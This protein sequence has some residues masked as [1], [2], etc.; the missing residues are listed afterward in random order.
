MK[1]ITPKRLSLMAMLIALQIVLSK[2]LMLQLTDSIRLSIDSV[3]IILAGVWFGPVAGGFVGVLG[4]LLGTVLF[5][6]AGAYFPLLTVAFM[7]IGVVAGLLSYAVQK[8]PVAVRAI[9]C[10][11]PAEFAGSLLFKSFALGTLYGLPFF[12]MVGIRV[13]PVAV[14]MIADTILVGVLDKLL[15][16]M[17]KRDGSVR[18]NDSSGAAD[19]SLIG[20]SMQYDEALD[21]IHH[22]TWRGSRLGLERTNELLSRIGN[23]HRALKFIHIAGTNGKGSTAA[24]LATILTAAGYRVGLYTSPFINRFNERMQVD[25]VSIPDDELAGITSYVRPHADEMADHPTEFEL[26]TVIA[27]E[28]FLRRNVDIVV[29]EVGMGGELDSTNVIDTPELAIITNIGLDHTRELGPTITDIARAKAGIIKPGGDVLI[30]DRNE[31]AD[32][33]FQDVSK[34]NGAKLHVTDHSR[35]GNVSP[36][37]SELRF[38]FSPYGELVCGLVGGYQTHNAAVAV[39][40]IELM[41]LKGWKIPDCALKTGLATV[42]WP[43]RFEILQKDP[44]FVADGGHNPQGV[45]AVAE[46]LKLH[47]PGQKITFLLGIMADKDIPQ[48]IDQ[49]GSIAAGFI[50][51]TPN[52]PRAMQAEAL[53]GLLSEH[54]FDA[55]P[56]DSVAS[57]VAAAIKSAGR[58]GVVCALGSLYMLGDVRDALGVVSD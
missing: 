20:S 14:V 30:Y 51:V 41:R 18:K 54:G 29:L 48:M 10:V 39:T 16:A 31:E 45:S 37:L 15:G 25:G 1:Q 28:F 13:L 12:T 57:G 19:S 5:P 2:F 47:F 33:V 53:A 22:V 42:R 9:A 50:T 36:S 11:I 56:C 8:R 7:I 4:D 17:A 3:P 46:S 38:D 55:T 35:I 32:A 58:D 21:Y 52:N 34:A 6:T 24:M 44:V 49:I 27:F 40:A 23:P 26:I 43:A